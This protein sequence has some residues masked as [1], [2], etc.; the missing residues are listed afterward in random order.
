MSLKGLAPAALLLWGAA[1]AFAHVPALPHTAQFTEDRELWITL[2]TDSLDDVQGTL[3]GPGMTAPAPTRTKNGVSMMK[4]RESQLFRISELMHEKYKRCAGF[5]AHE[6]ETEASEAM[7]KAGAPE[8][9]Q[10]AL[11][12][13]TLD[14]ADTANAL[15]ADL[16]EPNLYDTIV[17][18]SSYTTRYYKSA[19]GAEAALWLKTHWAGL[20]AGRPDVTVEEFVHTN[21]NQRSIILTIPGTTN[22]SEVVVVGGHLDSTVGSSGSNPSTLSPGADDDAS[23][24]ASITE[25]IRS[26]LAQNYRPERTVKFIGYAA[27]EAGLL[28]SQDIAR[29]HKNQGI[30]VVGVLQL[31]MTNF[32]GS[33]SYD[34]GVITD[35]T[36]AAQNTFLRSL[37][38]TYI[39][40]LKI[41]DTKCNYG[42]SD[43]ASWHN[44]GFPASFPFEATFNDSN[45]YIHTVNDTVAQSGNNAVHAVKFSRVTAAYVAELAKGSVNGTEGD[46][47]P[48]ASVLT[49]PASGATLV[50]PVTL[51]ANATDNVAVTKVEFY[52]DNV[53]KGSDT[54]APYSFVWDTVSTPN[55]AHVLSA[56]A[57][58][59]RQNVGASPSVS[60]TVNNPSTLAEYNPTLKVPTCATV[61]TKCDSGTLLTGRGTLGPEQNAPNTLQGACA[62]LSKGT[63]HSDE[64]NDRIV[65]STVDGTPFA[66]GKAVKIEATVWAYASSP[67]TDKLDLYYAAD[68]TAPVWVSLGTLTPSAGQ[69]QTLTKNYTLPSGG[70]LQAV[71]ARFRYGGST[72]TTACGKGEY[73]DHDDL[74]FAVTK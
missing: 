73:D 36:N 63:Y 41:V 38:T 4:V 42:C 13:Y 35:Y 30:N 25:V 21:Y 15:I 17:K 40:A 54:T 34:V 56:K 66:T 16:Q 60:V 52:V 44:Q 51:T 18:L 50:G 61:N 8:Q 22:A 33:A 72:S 71:R 55:G 53:L 39:P 59:T 19:T 23:G 14:N 46:T 62:D 1:P 11:V 69:A 28:G 3:R 27:E 57:Y 29:W 26:A 48:P 2:A 68:A 65:V 5:L 64:S 32:K 20:A 31:D 10:K 9:P 74:V 6:T 12:T 24:I 67:T 45:D 7:E 37:I 58:D 70:A 43:H 47:S 49:S